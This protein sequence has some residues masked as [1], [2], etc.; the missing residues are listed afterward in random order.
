MGIL[1]RIR[2]DKSNPP[3]RKE[4]W[5]FPLCI[6]NGPLSLRGE[7]KLPDLSKAICVLEFLLDRIDDSSNIFLKSN[8]DFDVMKEDQIDGRATPHVKGLVHPGKVQ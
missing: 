3:K 1:G 5:W 2:I 4:R 6:R 7:D 8:G